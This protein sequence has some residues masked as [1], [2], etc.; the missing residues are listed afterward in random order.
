M[1]KYTGYQEYLYVTDWTGTRMVPDT[2]SNPY[3]TYNYTAFESN[4]LDN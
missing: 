2:L 1:T 3:G 4:K